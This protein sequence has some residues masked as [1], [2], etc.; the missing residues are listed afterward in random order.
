M[1]RVERKFMLP[2]DLLPSFL[3]RCAAEYR[4]LELHGRRR[5]QYRTVYFDTSDLSFYHAHLTGRVPRRKLRVRT[6]VDTCNSFLEIK[7]RDNRGRTRKARVEVADSGLGIA[8]LGRLP[9][10]LVNGLHSRTL[11]E[12]L[13]TAFDRITLVSP[14]SSERVTIDTSLTFS[15]EDA[16]TDFTRVVYVEVKQAMRGPSRALS[17]LGELRRRPGALSKYCV[18]VATVL[19]GSRT[20]RFRPLLRQ[21]YQIERND[22]PAAIH[23]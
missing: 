21:L 20:N 10:A 11:R 6:Y 8:E 4:V 16:A 5:A 13:T 7:C 1:N 23:A 18:G 15:S 14:E 2:R 3:Q 22:I 12:V 19:P 9:E 17:A